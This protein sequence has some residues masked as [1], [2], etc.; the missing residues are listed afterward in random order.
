MVFPNLVMNAPAGY[1]AMEFGFTGANFTVAQAEVSGEHAVVLGCEILQ[2]GRA[3]VVLAGGGD[4][5]STV[6]LEGYHRARVLAG[7][8]GGREWSSPYDS[9]QRD[10][11]RRRRRDPG[12]R[13][14]GAGARA[15]PRSMRSSTAQRVSPSTPRATIGRTV[16]TARASRCARCSATAPSPSAAAPTRRAASIAAS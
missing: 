15:R 16:P 9:A 4:Q 2:S 1:V 3:D 12:A 13:A 5:L 6:L 11:P 7:Q 8:R 14:A 10:R